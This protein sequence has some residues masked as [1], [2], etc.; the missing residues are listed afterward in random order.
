MGGRARLFGKLGE[1]PYLLIKL[2]DYAFCPLEVNVPALGWPVDICKL[3]AHLADQQ[4]IVLIS[5]INSWAVHIIH[6]F[7]AEKR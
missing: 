6:L 1:V 7:L 3:N 2:V 4:P 5:P